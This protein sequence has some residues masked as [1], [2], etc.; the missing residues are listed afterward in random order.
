M[1][2]GNRNALYSSLEAC[3]PLSFP[4]W[5]IATDSTQERNGRAEKYYREQF[6][7][8]TTTS[9]V[10]SNRDIIHV[11][12]SLIWLQWPE[13]RVSEEQTP[14]KNGTTW[15]KQKEVDWKVRVYSEKEVDW[16]AR[17]YSEIRKTRDGWLGLEVVR[18]TKWTHNRAQHLYPVP[19]SKQY[20][21]R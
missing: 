16:K 13:V 7:S 20:S 1:I 3:A 18:G 5:G 6:P 11:F 2:S 14:M 9:T 21:Y 12:W 4:T 17:V 19:H 15:A 8:Y 10:Y